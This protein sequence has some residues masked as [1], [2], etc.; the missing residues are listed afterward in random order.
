M[1]EPEG[2]L[3]EICQGCRLSRGLLLP[4][5][6]RPTSARG[7]SVPLRGVDT[8]ELVGDGDEWVTGVA[9]D[10]TVE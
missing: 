6:R 9:E 7:G 4:R 5:Q 3:S 8:E 10:E 1:A 2:E